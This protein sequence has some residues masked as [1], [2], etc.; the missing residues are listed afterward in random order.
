MIL[1][2]DALLKIF[3][4]FLDDNA[5]IEAWHPLVHVCQKWRNMVFGSPRRLNL[6][7]HCTALPSPDRVCE[8]SLGMVAASLLE[9]I[10][11][12]MQVPFHASIHLKFLPEEDEHETVPIAPDDPNSFSGGPAPPHHL[13]SLYLDRAPFPGLPKL[14][15]S[16]TDLVRLT[17][18]HIPHSGYISPKAMAT[19]LS[20]LTKL[21]FLGLDFESPRS[22]PPDRESQRLLL[23]R[24]ALPALTQ[25]EFRGVSEYLEDLVARIDAPFL[26]ELY[27]TFFHQLIL[28]TPQLAQFIGRTP[29]LKVHNEAQIMFLDDAVQVVL[30][31]IIQKQISVRTM[32]NSPDWKLSFVAQVCSS[33]FSLIP[34]LEHLYICEGENPPSLWHDNDFEN[35]QWLEI[36]RPFRN[37][38]NLYLS[39]G[40]VPRIAPA[41]QELV[42]GQTGRVAEVLPGLGSL[43]LEESR[44]SWLVDESQPSGPTGESY[45]SKPVQ[46]ATG[47]DMFIAA[48]QLS[49]RPS[50]SRSWRASVISQRFTGPFD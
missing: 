22:Y 32:C 29:N 3:D 33:S 21:E 8:I 13:R 15:L 49:K 7:F 36:L 46:E 40:V 10:F 37:V 34:S 9:V 5:S 14:L 25:F 24:S 26:D 48:R 43:F 12:A 18:R 4:F 41:L 1:P 45:I 11:A 28:D 47:I 20:T 23:I 16:A 2:N 17:L 44:Q 19:C 39:E 38:K 31:S 35:D 50:N 27:I 30:G 6:H 42:E